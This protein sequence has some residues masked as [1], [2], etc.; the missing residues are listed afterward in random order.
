VSLSEADALTINRVDAQDAA[1]TVTLTVGG[2]VVA[3]SGTAANILANSLVLSSGGAVGAVGDALRLE[4]DELRLSVS[5]GGAH[6]SN[7]GD[8]TVVSAQTTDTLS[9]ALTGETSALTV[10]GTITV[11][12]GD[13]NLLTPTGV[14]FVGGGGVERGADSEQPATMTLA[15]SV[16]T[17]AIVIADDL[18]GTS[19]AWTMSTAELAKLGQSFETVVVGGADYEGDIS[20]SGANMVFADPVEI[21]TSGTVQLS[22][23]LSAQTL[24]VNA[25][26]AGNATV[27]IDG[28]TVLSVSNLALGAGVTIGGSNGSASLTI[29]GLSTDGVSQAIVLGGQDTSGTALVL[30]SNLTNALAASLTQVKVGTGEQWVSVTGDIAFAQSVALNAQ[31]LDMAGGATLTAAGDVVLSSEAGMSLGGIS[32]QGHTVT[33]ADSGAQVSSAGTGVNVTAGSVVFSGWGPASGSGGAPIQVSAASVQVY[34][35]SGMVLRDSGVDGKVTYL[36]VHGDQVQKQ[37]VSVLDNVSVR[38]QTVASTTQA[39]QAPTTLAPSMAVSFARQSSVSVATASVMFSGL[40]L[41][42][43]AN[44]NIDS[45]ADVVWGRGMTLAAVDDLS[46]GAD[47]VDLYSQGSLASVQVIGTGDLGITTG[48]GTESVVTAGL[49]DAVASAA[50]G[51]NT[52][53]EALSL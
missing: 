51:Y 19:G 22:G 41:N 35:P 18:S 30:G 27:R 40:N 23:H 25:S 50:F 4:V 53:T 34:A 8:L 33:I 15:S 49:T 9:V 36:V 46:G 1:S 17:K 20:M 43:D 48:T 38:A 24:A 16:K 52:W 3:G 10:S 13:V 39:P 29:K 7:A 28:D 44:A 32:A 37:L 6:V 5:E 26:S 11:S 42:E 21:Q 47:V 2:D 45:L 12:A 31:R 14:R